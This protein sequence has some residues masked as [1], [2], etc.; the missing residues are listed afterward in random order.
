MAWQAGP[1]ERQAGSSSLPKAAQ[2]RRPSNQ[3]AHRYEAAE[4]PSIT[5]ASFALLLLPPWRFCRRP[6]NPN[7]CAQLPVTSGKSVSTK[8]TWPW[9]LPQLRIRSGL[10]WSGHYRRVVHMEIVV[11]IRVTTGSF[12]FGVFGMR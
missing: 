8:T 9:E 6:L 5:T 11:W 10:R 7:A 4:S 3:T 2:N 12:T 1:K